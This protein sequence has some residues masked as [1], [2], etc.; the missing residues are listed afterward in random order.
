V[1]YKPFCIE[2][3]I[4]HISF[5]DLIPF[6]PFMNNLIFVINFIYQ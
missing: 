3:A 5:I 6:H 2:S 1:Q 4:R